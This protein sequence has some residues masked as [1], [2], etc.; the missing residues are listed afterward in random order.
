MSLPGPGQGRRAGS[1]RSGLTQRPGA[2]LGR[3]NALRFPMRG[4]N[5]RP[6]GRPRPVG[7]APPQLIAA[8]VRLNEAA[9]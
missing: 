4:Q 7:A 2:K 5:R 6:A 1:G 9:W 3:A 8:T